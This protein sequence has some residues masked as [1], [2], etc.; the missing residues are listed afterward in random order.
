[1]QTKCYSLNTSYHNDYRY[2]IFR[3]RTS[4]GA[5]GSNPAATGSNRDETNKPPPLLPSLSPLA[6]AT[7]V[8]WESSSVAVGPLANVDAGAVRLPFRVVVSL[9]GRSC[10]RVWFYRMWSSTTWIISD[11]T[12]LGLLASLRR[13][14]QTKVT[15]G[16]VLTKFSACIAGTVSH[17][18]FYYHPMSWN[19]VLT[20]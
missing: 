7:R 8:E 12:A 14:S 10:I 17:D 9:R 13:L 11:H 16:W 3:Y 4:G 20:Q 18:L 19:E 2:R 15:F 1:M 5:R 6:R